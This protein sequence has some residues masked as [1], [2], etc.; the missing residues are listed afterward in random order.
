MCT[1]VIPSIGMAYFWKGTM[2]K[3]D[4]LIIA[5]GLIVAMIIYGGT[6]LNQWQNKDQARQL[7]V[8]IDGGLVE[9]LSLD[10]PTVNRYEA[11]GG[12]NVVTI[13]H[14][15]AWISEADCETL[16]CVGEGAIKEVREAV[17]CL[18]HRFHIEIVGE[19]EVEIDAIA[20]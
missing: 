17:V 2:K 11:I 16:S 13:D 3:M 19:S 15:E 6:Q 20:Q 1:Y 7:N 5:M 8:Y 12:Y 4:A 14:G 9:T 10:E 18:P